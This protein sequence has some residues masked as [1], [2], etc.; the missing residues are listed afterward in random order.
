M[1][2]SSLQMLTRHVVIFDH[3]NWVRR[4]VFQPC[5]QTIWRKRFNTQSDRNKHEN[6]QSF[7]TLVFSTGPGPPRCRE[8]VGTGGTDWRWVLVLTSSVR[9]CKSFRVPTLKAKD[10]VPKT[11][12]SWVGL[13][14]FLLSI[15]NSSLC[16]LFIKRAAW[17]KL[18][19]KRP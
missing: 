15:T 6:K 2:S 12:V 19:T 10:E 3:W 7:I 17:A 13:W 9:L 4:D 16:Q 11:N 18:N 5:R 8:G 1:F 14:R